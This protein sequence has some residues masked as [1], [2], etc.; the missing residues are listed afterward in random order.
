MGKQGI[1]AAYEAVEHGK[2]F[3]IGM[4]KELANVER[5]MS[6]LVREAPPIEEG[7]EVQFVREIRSNRRDWD[8]ERLFDDERDKNYQ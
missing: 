4:S 6:K 1:R 8:Y 7:D 2:I 3:M 5:F